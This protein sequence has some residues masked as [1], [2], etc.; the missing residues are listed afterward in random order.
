[1]ISY[2]Q[3]KGRKYPSTQP[4]PQ[5]VQLDV[6]LEFCPPEAIIVDGISAFSSISSA[7]AFAGVKPHMVARIL[8]GERKTAK[9][10]TFTYA[11][12]MMLGEVL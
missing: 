10:H 3:V 1:M 9:G 7:A 2:G 11:R 4:L 5:D 6:L 8:R 12:N